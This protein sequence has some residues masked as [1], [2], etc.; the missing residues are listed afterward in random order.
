MTHSVNR[1]VGRPRAEGACHRA[2][3]RRRGGG[4]ALSGGEPGGRPALMLR[5]AVI[6]GNALGGIS[7]GEGATAALVNVAVVGTGGTCTSPPIRRWSTPGIPPSDPT[8]VVDAAMEAFPY[9]PRPL[10]L[11]LALA[12]AAGACGGLGSAPVLAV[13]AVGTV[14]NIPP[15]TGRD[16]GFSAMLDG[17]SVWVFGDTLFVEPAADGLRWR[18]SSWSWTTDAD[19]SDGV[20]PFEHAM[21]SDDRPLQLLPH[22]AEELAWNLAHEGEGCTAGDLCGSRLTPWPQAVVSAP[23][24]GSALVFYADMETGMGTGDGEGGWDFRAIGGSVAVWADPGAPASRVLPPLFGREEP[25]WGAAAVRVDDLVYAYACEPG[26]RVARVPFE[27]A[28]ERGEW[29]FWDG[30]GWSADWRRAVAVFDGAPLFS[31]HWSGYFGAFVAFYMPP[32]EEEIVLRT[33]PAPQ[34]PWSGPRRVGRGEPGQ[35]GAWDYALIAH[36]ELAREGGRIEILSYTRPTGF[37]ASETPLLE[38]EFAS[39]P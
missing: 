13:R 25:S 5:N 34:G 18:S 17:R 15:S 37:L 20:G 8:A 30:A 28:G 31:V 24:G 32:A 3:G 23:D 1:L 29:T 6:A 4:I 14:P 26:C 9:P 11:A 2:G 39:V 16:V 35:G 27:R 21:G 33:A 19:S 36:P 38:V 12:L 10:A 7:V 22:T